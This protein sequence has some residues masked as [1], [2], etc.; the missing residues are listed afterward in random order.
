MGYN[1]YEV[2]N[3]ISRFNKIVDKLGI[4]LDDPKT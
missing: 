4:K 1:P 2:I 3:E